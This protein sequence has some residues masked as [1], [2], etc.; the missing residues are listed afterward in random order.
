MPSRPNL[1][2]IMTDQ[3][4][5]DALG[6]NGNDIIR[7][8]NLDRIAASGANVQQYYAN[9]P[10]CVPSRV[11]LFTGRYPH[12]HRVRENHNLLESDR[13]V[14]L[15]RV[16]S[17][18]GYQ[19]GYVGKNHLL[20]GHEFE[21]FAY[22]DV[23]GHNHERSEVEE[24]VHRFARTRGRPMRETG[25]WAGAT[26]HDYPPEGTRPYVKASS[27][28]P[29]LRERPEDRPF[30]LCLSFS[31]P[32]APHLALEKYRE[33]YPLEEMELYPNREGELEEKAN[34]FGVKVRASQA[35]K[36]AE[37]DRRRF[38]A[39]Y[40]SMISWVD[41][42]IGRV[43]EALQERGLAE[44]TIIVFTSDHGEFCFEHGMC[45][46][47]LVLLDSL[48]HVP[49]LISRPG[50]LDPG[51][52][53]GTFVEEVDLLPTLLEMMDVEV[54][55]GVQGRSALPYLRG[56]TEGHKEAVYGEI[57]PPWL[58][59]PHATYE[60]FVRDWEENHE[61]LPSFNVPGDFTKSIRD[62]DYR[63]VWYGTGEE[64]LYDK[65]ADPHELHNVADDPDYAEARDRMKLRLLEWHAL[66]E[67]PLDPLSVR[68]LQDRYSDW[69]GARVNPGVMAGPYW[70]EQRHWQIP[71]LGPGTL[72]REDD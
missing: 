25:V 42:Q 52:R 68:Q 57:C 14:H 5:F 33:V 36:A 70:V 17:H 35:D 41:E 67:D 31:D 21:N 62:A 34:R 66:T 58:F 11:T 20:E 71:R 1:L 65:D 45:K 26:F 48:L 69:I 23:W 4:R 47:D 49:L 27:A 29:F 13:E 50:Q 39:V 24:E 54:P 56:E 18:A 10:V 60:D 9:C 3:Q 6:A 55:F 59:N 12:A 43:L 61:G 44:D 40:Y 63:Y 22:A 32:H 8:P 53:E 15:F 37:E 38:M 46:K 64:E 19:L 2:F 51:K 28:I 30:C 72:S 16:L 7:T